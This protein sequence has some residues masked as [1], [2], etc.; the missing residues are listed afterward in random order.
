MKGYRLCRGCSACKEGSIGQSYRRKRIFNCRK[1]KEVVF[2]K[3]QIRLVG[4]RKETADYKKE[5][6]LQDSASLFLLHNHSQ[7]L[8]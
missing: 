1:I 6:S 7:E 8:Y 5:I 4:G 3:Y 2:R